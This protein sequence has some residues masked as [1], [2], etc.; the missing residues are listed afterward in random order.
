VNKKHSRRR[1]VCIQLVNGIR[2]NCALHYLQLIRRKTIIEHT[3]AVFAVRESVR[4]SRKDCHSAIF[5]G[6][7]GSVLACLS[8]L[9]LA[10]APWAGN[11]A[12]LPE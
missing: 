10:E 11:P 7:A 3:L 5:Q 8:S 9:G 4:F 2:F 1:T 6:I 12:M